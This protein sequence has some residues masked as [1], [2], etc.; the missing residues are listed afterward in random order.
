MP[1]APSGRNSGSLAFTSRRASSTVKYLTRAA[2]TPLKGLT[3]RQAASEV[4]RSSRKTWLSAALKIVQVRFA[5]DFAA[6]HGFS[7]PSNARCCCGSRSWCAHAPAPW[8][9]L[10]SHLRSRVVSD[11]YLYVTEHRIDVRFSAVTLIHDTLA[12]GIKKLE[13]DFDGS[14]H[15]QRPAMPWRTA[16]DVPCACEPCL[17][18]AQN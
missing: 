2:S 8:L 9:G 18:P 5:D 13:I 14:S 4:T 11:R 16:R 10:A 7:D 1:L 17:V 12:V 3:L 15:S 6:A